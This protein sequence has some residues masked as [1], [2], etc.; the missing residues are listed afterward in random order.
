MRTRLRRFAAVGLV[1]TVLDFAVVLGLRLGPGLPVI[2]ADVISVSLAALASYVLHRTVTFADDPQL[3]WVRDPATFAWITLMAGV[4]DVSVIRVAVAVVGS[5]S[6]ADLAAA[7]AVALAAAGVFRFG[8]YRDRL[9]QQ[10]REDQ[11]RR[12]DREPPPGEVRVSVV[13][14]AYGEADRIGATIAR[15]REALAHEAEAGGLEIVVVDD[16][17]ADGTAEAARR[18]GADQ[19]IVQPHNRGKGAAVRAGMLA[20]RGR[21]VVFTDADLSYPPHQILRL[22]ADVEAG[23]DVVVGSRRHVDTV[24]LV[25]AR[26]LR[27]LSGRLFNSLTH[28]VLLGQYRD[29]QCGLKAF[30]SDAARLIFSVARVDGFAFDVEVFHLVERFRLSLAE[31]PVTLSNSGASTVRVGLD[32]ARMVRDLFRIRRWASRGLYQPRAADPR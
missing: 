28:A 23:W 5:H 16:G 9:F 22:L 19:V 6:A 27:E 17:S 8:A 29:T 14:P 12:P 20:A 4:V 3:R 7:K 30:R 24:T 13:V 11:A 2:V 25:H 21:A 31:V 10:V 32:A 18:A 26:R 15:L 1:V